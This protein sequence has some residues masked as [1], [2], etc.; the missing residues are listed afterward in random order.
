MLVSGLAR[1]I[2]GK[3]KQTSAEVALSVLTISVAWH[4]VQASKEE[5]GRRKAFEDAIKRPYFHVKPLDG[6]Q[7]LA[8]SRYLDYA[9]ERG[10]NTITTHLYE[11]CLVACAQYHGACHPP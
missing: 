7:L 8:W 3:G 4:G 6:A 10:D 2:C 9:E 5:V 11:R 1:V